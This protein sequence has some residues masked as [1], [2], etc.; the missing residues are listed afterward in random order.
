MSDK[1]A[2]R[3]KPANETPLWKS[4][5]LEEERGKPVVNVDNFMR[6]LEYDTNLQ[7]LLWYDSFHDRIFTMMEESGNLNGQAHEYTD[8]Q[9]IHLLAYLQNHLRIAR[10]S[11]SVLYQAVSAYAH[12]TPKN[13]PRDWMETLI[14]DG[15]S[16]IDAFLSDS[17]GVKHGQYE[18]AV[19]KNFWISMVARIYRPGC[20][21]DNLLILEGAQ[22]IGKNRALRAIGGKWYAQAQGGVD[23][24]DFYLSF[25]GK[26]LI[27]FGELVQLRRSEVERFKAA[28]S[29]TNDRYRSPYDRTSKD[30]PRQCIFVGTTNEDEWLNDYSGARRFWPVKCCEENIIDIDY[31]EKNRDQLFAE[32][33]KRFKE[34]ET[35]WEVPEAA[36]KEQENRRV[37]DP[38][39][40]IVTDWLKGHPLDV[41]IAEV[42]S[43][44]L[45]VN[46]DVLDLGKSKRIANCLKVA[47]RR[48]KHT[49]DGNCWTMNLT[50][51]KAE[52]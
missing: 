2:S 29:C 52:N 30:H 33:V 14:H 8:T 26:L 43:E 46:P 37:T 48:K 19:S 45:G 40:P 3:E 25:Q 36:A 50:E 7:G 12:R 10:A 17:L 16:R 31:I 39:E 27:E 35:W 51:P 21:V 11:D 15:V 1:I 44:A 38:W 47:G 5:G 23:D 32:A 13:E 41:T 49:M 42:A 24:K 18:R 34:N 28:I 6:V 20:Q 22:G 4:L 9:N